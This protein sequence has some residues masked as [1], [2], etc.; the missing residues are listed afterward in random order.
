MDS[1][2][3]AGPAQ[4]QVAWLWDPRAFYKLWFDSMSQAM[5]AYLRST[6]FLQFMQHGLRTMSAL[7]S[8]SGSAEA[9]SPASNHSQTSI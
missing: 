8:S 6:A 4:E 2:R 7:G 9:G 3:P 1:R 5:D